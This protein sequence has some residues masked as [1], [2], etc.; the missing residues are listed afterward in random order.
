MRQSFV[1]AV[2]R[3][4][5]REA[6]NARGVRYSG[7]MKS[8][9]KMG[10]CANWLLF[11]GIA[12]DAHLRAQ[13]ANGA[14]KT[15]P[16]WEVRGRS[17]SVY[18][19]G[20]IHFAKEDFFPLA[21][22]IE[23]AYDRSAV[24]IFETDLGEMK[25]METQSKLLKAGM[26]PTGE[27]LSQHV[28]KQ[29]YA[30]LQSWLKDA[31]GQPSAFDRMKPWLASV[32]VVAVELQKLG[33]NPNQGIDEHFHSR[34]KADKKEIR[35]LE[36]IDFQINLFTNL[37]REEDELFLKSMLED[38]DRFPK[39]FADVI[40]AWKSGNAAK[41][42]SLLLEITRKYPSIH[43]RFLTDL[44]R[45]WLPKIEELLRSDKNVFVVV[46]MAHLVGK[47]GVVDLLKKK[48][49]RVEQL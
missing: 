15:L 31:V 37:S 12:L 6:G 11:L 5:V 27:T 14:A 35:G 3:I 41:I 4:K 42:E 39:I 32:S 18:L 49:F 24:L 1:I 16:L 48:G 38:V 33:F 8:S 17:N 7:T 22:P 43:R 9:K 44:N 28:G 30:A 21:K 34:A 40:D 47:E 2:A 20:S 23:Q 13:P 46:G 45:A 10:V 36:T 29:T 25:S 19:L 26:C